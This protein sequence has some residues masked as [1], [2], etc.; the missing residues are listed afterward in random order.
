MICTH[1]TLIKNIHYFNSFLLLFIWIFVDK[2]I[3][4]ILTM[5]FK[6][7]LVDFVS[8]YDVQFS[9]VIYLVSIQSMELVGSLSKLISSVQ[10][11]M[12]TV[13]EFVSIYIKEYPQRF[14]FTPYI[15]TRSIWFENVE[16]RFSTSI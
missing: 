16:H 12:Y 9:G 13:Y 5:L 8:K 15:A 2:L 4:I 10:I 1:L 11:N 14:Y 7:F 6:L 3:R